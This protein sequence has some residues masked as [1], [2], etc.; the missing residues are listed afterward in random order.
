MRLQKLALPKGYPEE[1][2]N[3]YNFLKHR[4]DSILYK[5]NLDHFRSKHGYDTGSLFNSQ[6]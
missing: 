6:V 3:V 1:A 4:K 2:L 5:R